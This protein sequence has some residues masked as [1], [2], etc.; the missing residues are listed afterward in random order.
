MI[1]FRTRLVISYLILIIIP[2]SILGFRYYDHSTAVMTDL[3]RSNV[4][5]IVK[6]T[7]NLLDLKLSAIEAGSNSLIIDQEL[8]KTF[9]RTNPLLES[10][11][12]S[13]DR[14]ISPLLNKYFIREN[15]I[16]SVH[17]ATTYY[18]FGEGRS[19][20]PSGALQQSSLYQAAL[21]GEGKLQWIPTYEFARMYD[22]RYLANIDLDYRYMFSAVKQINSSNF[23]NGV[24]S[25]L[26]PAVE[27]P[28]LII[29]FKEQFIRNLFEVSVPIEGTSFMMLTDEGQIV[30]HSDYAKLTTKL[31]SPWFAQMK[32]SRSG[33][34]ITTFEDQRMILCYDTS[35]VTGW[36]SVAIVPVKELTSGM[37]EVIRDN[38][39]YL[40]GIVQLLSL[41]VAFIISGRITKPL[42]KVLIA[43][44]NVGEGNF[45]SRIA[46]NSSDE[47]G[48]LM[49]RFN[50][51]NDKIKLLIQENYEGKL[52]EAETQVMALNL[53][54]NPH[55]LYNTLNVINWSALENGDSETS[56]MLV[57]LSSML[58]YTTRNFEEMKPLEEELEWLKSYLYIMAKRFEGKFEARFFIDPILYPIK[59]PKLFL[60]PFVENAIIHGFRK[61][62][63][64]G[65]IDIYGW[66]E[67]GS[68]MFCVEDNGSGMNKEAVEALAHADSIGLHNV[69]KRIRLLH[70]EPYGVLINSAEGKGTRVNI[71]LPS[72]A[73]TSNNDPIT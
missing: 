34:L 61:M 58:H 35:E 17:L 11:L 3:A 25:Y 54:L 64:G 44:K 32:G 37:A 16:Y 12:I 19:F 53:Q 40:T 70:G 24:F 10:D 23:Q 62:K 9:N 36:I 72:S 43:M 28:L 33:T 18:T 15:D 67:E 41:L 56:D 20:I 31:D 26:N 48:I 21:Q 51:M 6:K 22:Q 50:N 2:M 59:V 69:G 45:D 13:M 7:N 5:E 27:R 57:H 47:F 73:R 46:V 49:H 63:S 60:Q 71:R 65:I 68:R 8:Y 14:I 30:S 4:L 66:L 39:V 42:K 52:R 38:A 29:N 1:R 55:F